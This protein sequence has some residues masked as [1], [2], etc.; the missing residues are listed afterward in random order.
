M[1]I[2]FHNKRYN[3]TKVVFE[4]NISFYRN[5]LDATPDTS[6]PAETEIRTSALAEQ[7]IHISLYK[8]P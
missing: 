6:L 8:N 3:K 1:L 7:G 2:T 4:R 5:H